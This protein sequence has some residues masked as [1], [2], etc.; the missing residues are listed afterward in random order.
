MYKSIIVPVDLAHPETVQPMLDKAEALL[1][2]GGKLHVLHVLHDIPVYVTSELPD[3]VVAEISTKAEAELK[4]LA[5]K[6]SVSTDVQLLRGHPSGCIL[7]AADKLDADLIFISS[8]RPGLAD[9]F[10]GSTAAR[11]VRHAKCSVLVMR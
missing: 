6:A 10:L 2:E 3:E 11:V 5:G 8:H 9:Y 4:A 7:D 1:D